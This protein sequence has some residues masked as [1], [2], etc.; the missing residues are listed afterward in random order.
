MTGFP[1]LEQVNPII[2]VGFCAFPAF[3]WECEIFI[4]SNPNHINSK[5]RNAHQLKV[6]DHSSSVIRAAFL[7]L[8]KAITTLLSINRGLSSRCLNRSTTKRP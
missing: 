4:H 3:F 2:S 8:E 5:C 1:T 7:T 6:Q